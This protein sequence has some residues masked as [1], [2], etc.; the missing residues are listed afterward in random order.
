MD[1]K[2]RSTKSPC[3]KD[4]L[5]RRRGAA[6]KEAEQLVENENL[7]SLTKLQM[8]RDERFRKGEIQKMSEIER[9]LAEIK[10]HK[11]FNARLR[12]DLSQTSDHKI[13]HEYRAGGNNKGTTRYELLPD[14]TIYIIDTITNLRK[15]E[16]QVYDQCF[17]IWIYPNDKCVSWLI[18]FEKKRVSTKEYAS[19]EIFKHESVVIEENTPRHRV[20]VYTQTILA[21]QE[22]KGSA[23]LLKQ[24]IDLLKH[25]GMQTKLDELRKDEC[26]GPWAIG[27]GQ[28]YRSPE[29]TPQKRNETKFRILPYI[30]L[31]GICLVFTMLVGLFLVGREMMQ[32]MEIPSITKTPIE[33][34]TGG[35]QWP[36]ETPT[37]DLTKK[38]QEAKRLTA[39]GFN[40]ISVAKA[41]LDI[42]DCENGL[43]EARNAVDK[44]TH[45]IELNP[46]DP[47]AYYCRADGYN[48]LEELEK[49]A[50]DFELALQYGLNGEKK[51][52][53]ERQLA[54]IR[55]R[56]AEPP[57][58]INPIQFIEGWDSSNNPINPS[59]TCN[60]V[61]EIINVYWKLNGSCDNRLTVKWKY[62]DTLT[63]YHYYEPV[64][65][66]PL[67]GSMYYADE[68]E[69]LSS[70][71]WSVEVWDGARKLGESTCPIPP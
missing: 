23:R 64:G 34:V 48:L 47:E 57:C 65:H 37:E 61:S 46:Q 40:H 18:E 55:G 71:N 30:A 29:Y 2:N 4:E 53:A 7:P 62:N 20:D 17:R 52:E 21:E 45:A 10:Y 3:S 36:A 44:C 33:I 66:T 19:E 11:E 70:G 68:G 39:E 60:D 31:A 12:Y 43:P 50:D 51:E 5:E 14:G 38:D 26:Y 27:G 32:R 24:N 54:E 25:E 42:H 49:A 59:N 69:T 56:L 15:N 28:W 8:E 1:A 63:C 6:I 22:I 16:N 13:K 58:S 67:E 35:P 9:L 41:D